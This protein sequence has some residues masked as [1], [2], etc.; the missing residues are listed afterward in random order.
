MKVIG[1]DIGGTKTSI[2]M[3][4]IRKGRIISKI[5][6]PSK[7]YKDDKFSFS[8]SLDYSTEKLTCI[9]FVPSTDNSVNQ[10]LDDLIHFCLENKA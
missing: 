7:K 6:I 1:I 8:D 2:G 5:V 9:G 3:V 4:D 10:E